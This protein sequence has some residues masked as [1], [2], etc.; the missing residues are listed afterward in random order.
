MK[1]TLQ[2]YCSLKAGNIFTDV[3]TDGCKLP[4]VHE[5]VKR[6]SEVITTDLEPEDAVDERPGPETV[7]ALT[8]P[9]ANHVMV[10]G[11]PERTS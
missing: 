4:A 5:K 10:A 3:E 6:L 7:H 2:F 9:P 11:S 8:R 1:I